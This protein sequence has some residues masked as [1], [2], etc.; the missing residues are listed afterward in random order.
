M[1]S[2]VVGRWECPQCAN[3]L[4]VKS[5]VLPAKEGWVK[6]RGPSRCS[7]G[8]KGTFG[9]IGIKPAKVTFYDEDSE[10]MIAVPK[11]HHK[12][13]QEHTEKFL[14]RKKIEERM[15]KRKDQK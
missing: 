8:R 14:K 7:C 11:E 1:V 3:I 5:V 9:L 4:T 12:E 15:A 13:L 2:G 10:E 6:F